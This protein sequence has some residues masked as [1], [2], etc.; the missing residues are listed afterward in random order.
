MSMDD[1]NARILVRL[2]DVAEVLQHR[3]E[4]EV[5]KRTECTLKQFR[6]LH[7][8]E[9]TFENVTPTTLARRLS[10]SKPTVSELL[11]GL[12]SQGWLTRVPEFSDGR[13][14][15]LRVTDQ[16]RVACEL[17]ARALAHAAQPQL[18]SLDVEEKQRL[19]TILRRLALARWSPRALGER[20]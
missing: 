15:I 9:T 12:R 6:I 1:L 5:D 14:S 11:R 17:Y 7:L 10:C 18:A 13:S 8:L 2:W 19:V 20:A 3:I 16:G 4:A